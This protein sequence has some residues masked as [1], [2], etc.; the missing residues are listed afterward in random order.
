MWFKAVMIVLLIFIVMNLG[1]ALTHM[2]KDPNSTRT[3]R[4]LTWRIGLSIL[5]FALLII[6]AKFGWIEPHAGGFESS[7]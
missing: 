3:V 5:L 4:S 1:F 6:G 2:L 7:R